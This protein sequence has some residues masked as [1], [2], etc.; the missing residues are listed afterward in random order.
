[1][2]ENVVAMVT[3][4]GLRTLVVLNL[5]EE[6]KLLLSFLETRKQKAGAIP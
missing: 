6:L 4:N 3:V 1:M 5:P 2:L